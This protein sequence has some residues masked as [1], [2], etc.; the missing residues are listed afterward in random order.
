MECFS[1]FVKCMDESVKHLC[2]TME[3]SAKKYEEGKYDLH[4]VSV[5]TTFVARLDQVHISH[6]QCFDAV[7]WAAGRASGL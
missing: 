7:G 6:L 1:R 4:C 5:D 2:G 3:R